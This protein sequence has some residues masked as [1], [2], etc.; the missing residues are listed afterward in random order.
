M[1]D[2]QFDG[3]G[4]LRG[5]SIEGGVD[6]LA[7][8]GLAE[9]QFGAV[10]EELGIADFSGESGQL[11]VLEGPVLEVQVEAVGLWV[12]GVSGVHGFHEAL[13]GG[14]AA[15]NGAGVVFHPFGVAGESFHCAFVE[16]PA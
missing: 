5:E 14:T 4:V 13:G 6:G 8:A 7:V 15:V 9:T 11:D 12:L 3:D 2:R 16:I 1:L 10:V